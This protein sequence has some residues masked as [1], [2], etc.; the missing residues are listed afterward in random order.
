MEH[1]FTQTPFKLSYR[2]GA[3]RRVRELGTAGVFL[4]L[5]LDYIQ[6]LQ[7]FPREKLI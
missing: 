1:C 3:C 4:C 7:N 5:D 6:E 2:H